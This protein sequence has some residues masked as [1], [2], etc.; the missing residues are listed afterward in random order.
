MPA[1]LPHPRPSSASSHSAAA[2]TPTALPT[3]CWHPARWLLRTPASSPQA[4]AG[5]VWF[6]MARHLGQVR[7]R[8]TYRGDVTLCLPRGR[9]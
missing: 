2:L 9:H 6:W 5:T 8:L 4:S 7:G 1:L 3:C